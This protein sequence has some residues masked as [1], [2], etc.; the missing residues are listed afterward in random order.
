MQALLL[1]SSQPC[2][3]TLAS[4]MSLTRDAGHWSTSS[5]SLLESRLQLI[6]ALLLVSS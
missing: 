5:F 2:E 6:R 1:L 3:P 4:L